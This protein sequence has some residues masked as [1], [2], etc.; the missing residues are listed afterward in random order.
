M[1]INEIENLVKRKQAIY[2]LSV[3]K[4]SNKFSNGEFLE[5]FEI[6]RLPNYI[7]KNYAK[8]Q[9]WID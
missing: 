4:K 8:Y 3:D 2:N 1:S 7:K 9:D 5:K 6:D